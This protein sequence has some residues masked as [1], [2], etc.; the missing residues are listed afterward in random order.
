MLVK[1]TPG[2]SPKR[3]VEINHIHFT[4]ELLPE[5]QETLIKSAADPISED[6]NQLPTGGWTFN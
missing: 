3:E 4:V 2:V 1:N 5:I 6:N